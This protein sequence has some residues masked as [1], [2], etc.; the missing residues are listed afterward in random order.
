MACFL[1]GHGTETKGLKKG[2]V[3]MDLIKM[4][5]GSYQKGSIEK[6]SSTSER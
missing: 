1:T 5:A 3:R 6:L 4:L 2:K